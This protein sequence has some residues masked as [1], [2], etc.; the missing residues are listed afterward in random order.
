MRPLKSHLRDDALT[1]GEFVRQ[2][3]KEA[4]V[5]RRASRP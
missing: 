4:G 1:T 5:L 2:E 3:T